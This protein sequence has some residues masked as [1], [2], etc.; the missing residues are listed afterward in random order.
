MAFEE[1]ASGILVPPGQLPAPSAGSVLI[2]NRSDAPDEAVRHAV[3]THFEEN[4][5]SFGAP[6]GFQMYAG[7]ET[8][9][10]LARSRYSTPANVF[11]EIKL[12]RDLSLRDDDIRA[13]L[14]AMIAIAY[15]EGMENFSADE[16]TQIVFNKIAAKGDYDGVL[17]RIMLEYLVAQQVTTV[18]LYTRQAFDFTHSGVS[19][20]ISR[21]VAAPYIG[22]IP[23]EYIR[24]M[25][26]DM[27]NN[28]PLCY[29]PENQKVREWLEAYFANSVTPAKRAE[30]ARQQPV[31]ASLFVDKVEVENNINLIGSTVT[32]YVLNPLMASR[33][34]APSTGAYPRPLMVANFALLEAKRLL[35]L[36]DYAYLTGGVNFLVIAKKGTD[37]L[38]GQPEEIENLR[39]V[40]RRSS[41]SGVIVGDHRLNIE[42]VTPDLKEVLNASKRKLLARQV[43]ATMLR[44]PP[45][46]V[47]ENNQGEQAVVEILSAV[48]TSDRND[49]K[50]H[51]ENKIYDDI[52]TRN[53]NVFNNGA[54]KIWHQKI[55]LQGLNF[56][57][58]LVLKLNDRGAI[59]RRY[60][61]EAGGFDYDAAVAEK[62]RETAQG[63]DDIMAPPLI[64]FSS[65][66]V[67]PQDNNNG[68]PPGS[69]GPD[70]AKPRQ[71]IKRTRGETV[72]ASYDE[73]E[74][75]VVR[76]GELTEAI[77][78]QFPDHTIGRVTGAENEALEAGET[79]QKGAMIAVAVNRDYETQ[80]HR[81]VRLGND[82]S[83]IV[84][85]TSAGALVTRAICFR[86]DSYTVA[87]AE[88]RA[89]AWGFF[90]ETVDERKPPID[91]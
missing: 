66:N 48:I 61:V 84:G 20:T 90:V 64:P 23:A 21:T 25:G 12:A 53:P 7:N 71:L 45:A 57:T 60:A 17:K 56:F 40:L 74:E 30:L 62:Q 41:R 37:N 70:P 75:K 87:A 13:T 29:V 33:M 9:S 58:D 39:E 38:P 18:S 52:V 86:D 50:R 34:K 47:E 27:F 83:L 36:L 10:M 44:L 88:D 55:V 68:R 63:H 8:G 73:E 26:D 46:A 79:F 24:V 32:A 1:T 65:P 19:R 77:L 82:V 80:E 89:I 54:A 81:A 85:Q 59:P 5:G 67:G 16:E 76:I 3:I 51:V 91:L 6:T 49:V 42:I 31:W 11:D 43:S 15:R 14:G 78:E 4:V 28:A 35:N 2:D 69:T 22:I 72:K